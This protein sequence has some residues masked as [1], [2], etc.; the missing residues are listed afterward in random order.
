MA[1]LN[2]LAQSPTLRAT[3]H[4]DSPAKGVSGD[5]P[6][7]IVGWVEEPD[8]DGT[9]WQPLAVDDPEFPGDRLGST[10]Y[11]HRVPFTVTGWLGVD[12]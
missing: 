5:T 9:A 11:V 4:F 12:A 10:A 1:A 6:A 2:T 3:F 7:L 8:E